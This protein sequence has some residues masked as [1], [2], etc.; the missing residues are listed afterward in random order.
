[1]NPSTDTNESIEDSSFLQKLRRDSQT[2]DHGTHPYITAQ[3]TARQHLLQANG[4]EQTQQDRASAPVTVGDCMALCGLTST[5][6]GFRT[7]LQPNQMRQLVVTA[8]VDTNSIWK[9]GIWKT[10]REAFLH[11]CDVQPHSWARATHPEDRHLASA[12]VLVSSARLPSRGK[13]EGGAPRAA[14]A[15]PPSM[16]SHWGLRCRPQAVQTKGWTHR[17]NISPRDSEAHDG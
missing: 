7:S 5:A 11:L 16:P 15:R 4:A 1:M 17:A 13:E 3:Q 2:Q 14:W 10:R 9:W 8:N 12:A 6:D